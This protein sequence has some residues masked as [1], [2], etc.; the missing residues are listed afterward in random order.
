MNSD[1]CNASLADNCPY[2]GLWFINIEFLE[3]HINNECKKLTS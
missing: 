3:E 1:C 2:C